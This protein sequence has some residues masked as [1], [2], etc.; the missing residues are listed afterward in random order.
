MY[1][2]TVTVESAAAAVNARGVVAAWSRAARLLL[3]YEP[4]EVIGRSATDLLAA[5]LPD[6]AWRSLSQQE[7]WTG[8]VALRDRDGHTIE[9]DVRAYPLVGADDHVGWF[10]HGAPQEAD[11]AD[12][13]LRRRLLQYHRPVQPAVETAM[14]YRP[15]DPQAGVG[16]DWFDVTPQTI[17]TIF[18]DLRP[19]LE[20]D[21]QL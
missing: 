20:E 21:G 13:A 11:G 10:I 8:R 14:R 4:G 17:G 9:A 16:G 19:L 7:P 18:R 5:G 6:S 3:G 1:D 12:L 15:A 2:N